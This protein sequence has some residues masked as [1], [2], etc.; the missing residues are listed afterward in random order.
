MP[1]IAII[2]DEIYMREELTDMLG[3]SGYDPVP[4][5][6]FE[7]APAQ[8]RALSP[9]LVLLDINLPGPS[10][11]EICKAIQSGF[12][13]SILVLTARDRL[14]D[15]LHA[16]GLGADD[17]LTKPCPMERLLARIR[18]LLR[19]APGHPA[20]LKGRGFS[21]DPDTLT[22]YA[23]GRSFRLPPNE[24]KLL[25]MLLKNSP[26]I[27]SKNE[28]SQALWGTQMY[29]DENA[30]QVNLTRLRKTLGKLGFENVIETVRGQGYRYLNDQEE[31]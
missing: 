5:T 31:L 27:V 10:G 11:F 19:R 22:L 8:I 24:G 28:L 25:A 29:I 26:R 16:L 6:D 7:N 2:E 20:F 18:N 21:L 15:E 1:K 23:P 14:E 12:S 9:D 30:L 17:Y 4:I 3:K 13:G